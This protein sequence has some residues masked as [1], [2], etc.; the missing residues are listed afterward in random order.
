MVKFLM[1][2][3]DAEGEGLHWSTE[4]GAVVVVDRGTGDAPAVFY[5]SVPANLGSANVTVLIDSLRL[6]SPP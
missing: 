6:S 2:Y 3:S 1:N 5:A 4:L